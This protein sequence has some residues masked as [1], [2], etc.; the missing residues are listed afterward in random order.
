MIFQICDVQKNALRVRLTRRANK[1]AVPPAFARNPVPRSTRNA[2][3][4]D[5][6]YPCRTGSKEQLQSETVVLLRIV[7][8][9]A[10]GRTLFRYG[11]SEK[12]QL[13][14]C[15]CFN[16]FHYTRFLIKS[17]RNF[18]HLFFKRSRI[19]SKSLVFAIAFSSAIRAASA[20]SAAAFSAAIRS[21]SA[22]AAA[23]SATCFS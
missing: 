16:Y 18:S 6:P 11:V 19:S 5:S 8:L 3:S 20:A 7:R 23:A 13:F 4:C 17:Q 9:S 2:A 15:L 14:H 21:S 22:F 1:S 12:R 10:C